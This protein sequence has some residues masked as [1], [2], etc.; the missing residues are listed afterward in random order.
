MAEEN[1]AQVTRHGLWRRMIVG[2]AACVALLI[3]FHRPILLAIGRQLVLR[4]AARENL[5][6]DFRLEGNPFSHLT[7]RNFRALPTGASAIESIDI[8]EFYVDYSLFGLTRH[9]FS[10]FLEDVELRSAQVVLDPARAPPRKPRSKQKLTLPSVFPERIRL[11][12][13]TL[14]VR[15]EPNDFVVEHVDLNLNP[16]SPGEVRIEKLQLPSGDSWSR[17][18]GQASY[19]NKNLVLRDLI[20]SDQEQVRLLNI[21]ASRIDDKTLGLKLDCAIGGGQL[22][23]SAALTET[24]SS[25]TGKINVAAQQIA[26]ESLNKFLFLKEDSLSGKIERLTVDGAG[27]IDVPRTWIGAISLQISNVDRPEIHFDSGVVEVSAEQG[28][29]TLRSADIVQD[30]N[31][32]HFRGTMELPSVIEDFG[33][34]PTTLEITGTAPDLQRVTTGTPVQLTGSAQFTGKID[35]VN[36]KIEGTL[37][38]TGES[39]GFPGGTIEKLSSTLR[40]SKT[41]A[42][43][44]T[45]L[46]SPPPASAKRPWFADLRT[47]MEFDLAAIRY[48]D[49]IIDSVQGSLNGSDDILGLDRLSLRRNQNELNV[50][51]RYKL[52]EEVGKA[53]SQPADLDVALNAPELGDF[54]VADSPNK[55]SGPLQMTAQIEWRQQT[56][57]GQVSISGSNLKM[58][59]LVFHELSTQCSISNNIVYLNDCRASLNDSDFFYATGRLNLRQPHHYNGKVSASIANLSTLQ[60]L[61]RTFGNQNELA[62]SVTLDWEGNGDAQ[63]SRSSGNLKVVLEKGRYGNTQSLRANIDA[64]YSPEGLDVPIIFFATGNTDFQAVAQAKGETLEI[65]RIQLDQGQARFASGYISFPL[66]WR[67]LGTNAPIIPSSGKVFATIQSENLDLKKLFSDLGI[68]AGTS[69]TL[70]ARLD[71]DGTIGDLNARLDLQM[72]DLRNDRWPKMEPATFVL[73]AQAVHDRLTVL[74]KLQQA[75]IQPLELNADVPFDIPKIVR[76]RKLPDD[77]PIT[78]KARLPRSSVN[79][80]RQFVPALEQ[81]DGN[82]GLDV[83]VSG[84]IGKPVFSG[85]G[86]MTVN[87]ARFTNATLPALTNF[88]ARLSFAQNALSLERFGGDLAGGPFTMSGRVTFPKLIEPTLDLQLKANSVLVARNDTLTARADA[89]IKVT[90]PFAA[91]TVS[92]NVAMTNSHILKNIDLIPIG[93]PGRPAPEPP[94]ER[95]QFSFPDPPLRDWKFDVAIKTKDPVLIRGNLATGGAIADIKLTGTGLHPELQGTVRLENV[96]ATLPF[97][98]LEVSQGFLYFDPSDSMN[99]RLELRGTSVIRDYTVR[100]YVYGTV[101]APEAIFTSE[102]PLPQEE[103][104]SLI[105]TGATRQELSGRGNVLAGRAAMLL[106]Q[107][108]YRKIFKKGEPTQSNELFNRLDLDVG[109]VDPRTG[110]QQVSARFKISDQFVLVGDVGVGGDYRGMLKYLIRFR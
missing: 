28:R 61:L 40:A 104:I 68:K 21:D 80:V 10:H 60:P 87:V 53:P 52:P 50:R 5:K 73:N 38:M 37:G 85:A 7:V 91:A 25:L 94:S 63:I 4:Y 18:S 58:R 71:A 78:A 88:S 69:G 96:E 103:I 31:E 43:P 105:A 22:S 24:S 35:I 110:R 41:I 49:H 26:A 98:R 57:N 34:T 76:A 44:D 90:G 47:A 106:V 74:G 79:F 56:A 42:R 27:T 54:W 45:R 77:T 9:G 16:R 101:L 29:A 30:K 55:L 2:L 36:A 3:I 15:N 11:A 62:G 12:D 51:G 67:N 23:T 66:V 93:L 81:L 33:R 102:P 46:G 82:L 32:L 75:Q 72:R 65:T 89:D 83:D 108:L 14:V 59:D 39:I 64:S 95:P 100:V 97:S 48:R 13:V 20:L 86:D 107:Q 92:G 19:A 99:P 1:Q 8:D 70:S 17:I 109:A 6:I 84:T